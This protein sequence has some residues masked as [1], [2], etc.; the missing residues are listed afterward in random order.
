VMGIVMGILGSWDGLRGE[1]LGE[2][3][4]LPG[5]RSASFVVGL[6]LS[7]VCSRVSPFSHKLL[8]RLPHAYSSEP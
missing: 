6:C 3:S 8:V 7:S 2:S 4:L 1:F 5:N